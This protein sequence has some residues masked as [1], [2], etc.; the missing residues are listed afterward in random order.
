MDLYYRLFQHLH[1]GIL[2]TDKF[3]NIIYCN[4]SYLNFIGQELD[5]IVGK[6]I[7]NVRPGAKLPKVIETGKP[8]F[9]LLRK[10]GSQEYFVNIYPCLLY[11]SPSPRD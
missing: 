5:Q 1:E 6:P 3:S 4:K 10:E 9:G 2:I 11:T 8:I 7:Y